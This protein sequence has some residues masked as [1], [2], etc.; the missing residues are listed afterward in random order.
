MDYRKVYGG[1][2][3]GGQSLCLTCIY[4]RIIRGFAESEMITLCDRWDSMRV[5]FK[6]S[7]CS[8]YADRRLPDVEEMEKIAWFP[9]QQERRPQGGLPPS[10][11]PHCL[12]GRFGRRFLSRAAPTVFPQQGKER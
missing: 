1:T 11:L 5:P 9:A 6:V 2:P 3:K 12:S 10:E 8:D 7:E 4:A